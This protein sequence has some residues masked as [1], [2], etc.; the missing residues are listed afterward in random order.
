M[1][2]SYLNTDRVALVLDF[3]VR[4]ALSIAAHKLFRGTDLIEPIADHD[5]ANLRTV[6]L[7]L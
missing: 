5:L 3:S 6:P 1:Q 7:L 4:R 2:K